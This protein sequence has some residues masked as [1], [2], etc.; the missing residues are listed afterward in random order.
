LYSVFSE[1][2]MA[3]LH[4]QGK[5]FQETGCLCRGKSC[6]GDEIEKNEMGGACGT[7]GGRERCAQGFGG[8]T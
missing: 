5:K 8:E 6:A 2:D 1:D 3:N 7:Y 4:L